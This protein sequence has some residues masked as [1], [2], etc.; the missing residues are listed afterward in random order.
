MNPR[1]TG[2]E[3]DALTT[4]PSRRLWK[5]LPQRFKTVVN[6]CIAP[7]T[8]EWN[9]YDIIIKERIKNRILLKMLLLQRLVKLEGIIVVQV[10]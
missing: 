3:A 5:R 4:T 10:S 9:D 2:C 1:S 7:Q 6:N 8:T